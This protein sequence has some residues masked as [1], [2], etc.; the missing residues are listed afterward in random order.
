MDQDGLHGVAGPGFLRLGVLHDVDGT[1]QVRARVHEDMA[2]AFPRLYHR[3]AGVLHH[4]PDQLVAPARND[5]VHFA[6]GSQDEV[7]VVRHAVD[8]QAVET[9]RPE[10]LQVGQ[11]AILAPVGVPHHDRIPLPFQPVLH[12]AYDLGPER[13]GDVGHYDQGE[14]GTRVPQPRG[15]GIPGI[16]EP[17]DGLVDRGR[18]FRADGAPLVG[19][20]AGNGAF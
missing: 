20:D 3:H 8:D 6:P 19:D 17:G 16:A 2:V 10:Q 1:L 11:F 13:V 14:V 18:G 12:R 4:S 7:H 5:H 9:P 15:E